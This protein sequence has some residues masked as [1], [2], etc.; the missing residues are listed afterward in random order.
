MLVGSTI[1]RRDCNTRITTTPN[2]LTLETR[3]FILS[4][5]LGE[6]EMEPTD[7]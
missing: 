5:R 3:S 6:K 1:V 2:C 4:H 7:A